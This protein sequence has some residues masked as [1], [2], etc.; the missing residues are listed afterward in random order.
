MIQLSLFG[1]IDADNAQITIG[2][3]MSFGNNSDYLSAIGRKTQALASRVTSLYKEPKPEAVPDTLSEALYL[4]TWTGLKAFEAMPVHTFEF[5]T[6]LAIRPFVQ[7]TTPAQ[8]SCTLV[9]S[10][11]RWIHVCHTD[12][13]ARSELLPAQCVATSCSSLSTEFRAAR[14]CPKTMKVQVRPC[15]NA[16]RKSPA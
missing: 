11:K 6:R 3:H 5:V 7:Q 16:I 12:P 10:G 14:L 2:L 1:E 15:T 13:L 4:P 9:Q 8:F